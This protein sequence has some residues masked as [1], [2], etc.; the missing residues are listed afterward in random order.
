MLGLR[1]WKTTARLFMD[2]LII[3]AGAIGLSLAYELAAKGEKVGIVER[4][5]VGRES[6]WA[7]AGI[8]PPAPA[9]ADASPSQQL[10]GLA[11]RLHPAWHD[12]LKE[13]TGVENG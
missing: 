7:G 9:D 12:R 2:T 4:S 3:G 10:A 11:A 13:E 1:S 8:V 6:S 5:D